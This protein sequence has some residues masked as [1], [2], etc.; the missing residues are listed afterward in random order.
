MKAAV[1]QVK[2]KEASLLLPTYDRF[3]VL[4]E[5]GQGMYLY[6]T[7]GK[8]YLDF[9]SGIGVS[10]LGYAH[11][12]IQKTIREQSSKLIHISNLFYHRYQSELAEH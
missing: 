10:A 7:A 11:P 1:E 8:K 3:P 4:F 6:D 9:L 2:K 12:A 5:R